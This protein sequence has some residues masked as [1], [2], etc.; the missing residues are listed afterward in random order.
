[1]FFSLCVVI[2][3]SFISCSYSCLFVC[4]FLLSIHSLN[5]LVFFFFGCVSERKHFYLSYG[6]CFVCIR[7]SIWILFAANVYAF[8]FSFSFFVHK[9]VLAPSISGIKQTTL[10]LWYESFYVAFFF[11]GLFLVAMRYPQVSQAQYIL[12]YSIDDAYYCITRHQ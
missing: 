7:E 8:F 10:R 1:M 11:L 5:G 3:F 12:I 9:F 2:F 6:S 4:C